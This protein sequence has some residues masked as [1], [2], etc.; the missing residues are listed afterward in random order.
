M[1]AAHD[2]T[3]AGADVDAGAVAFAGAAGPEAPIMY[4]RCYDN[5]DGTSPMAK[6]TDQGKGSRWNAV[7]HGC[8]A[9]ILLPADLQQEVARCTAM[10]TEHY[11]P[12]NDFQVSRIAKMGR[13]EAQLARL[14]TMKVIDLQR[15][16]DRA[17]LVWDQDRG[18]YIDQLVQTLA[19]DA[20]VGRA[21]ARSKQGVAWLLQTWRGLSDVLKITGKW[22]DDQIR[23]GLDLAGIRSELREAYWPKLATGTT[24]ERAQFVSD[25]VTML[26]QS[27]EESL[28]S[29]DWANQ[30]MAAAG[31]P[32]EEDADTKR[33]RKQESRV[34]LDYRRAKAELEESRAQAAAAAASPESAPASE[35]EPVASSSRT[36][37]APDPDP[38]PRPKTS[39][40]AMNFLEK[41]SELMGFD[42]PATATAAA[43]RVE[44]APP[45]P[46]GEPQLQPPGEPEPVSESESEPDGLDE[47]A[48]YLPHRGSVVSKAMQAAVAA[49]SREQERRKA[50]VLEKKARKAARRRRR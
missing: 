7:R 5:A 19:E 3:D 40:A 2:L 23:L 43:R 31:M 13:L 6:E 15:T 41:R 14:E 35:P 36:T 50:R 21:L 11:R 25:Q 38:P 20:G 48:A 29:L 42:I 47:P 4:P 39:H 16:M 28:N 8:M 33:I 1:I 24:E 9:Q 32:M 26:E 34:K 30:S 17:L 45:F 49:H 46:G 10:L 12:T 37:P 44:V 22:T 18:V 27:L